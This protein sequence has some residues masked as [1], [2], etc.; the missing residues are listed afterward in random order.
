MLSSH[1][2]ITTQTIDNNL[3]QQKKI[4]LQVLRLDKVHPIISGNKIFKLH[5][6][7]EGLDKKAGKT[8]ITF[9]GAYSNHLVATAYTCK[10]NGITCVGIVRG[11]APKQLSHTLQHCTE[12]GMQLQFISREAYHQK[13]NNDFTGQ[14]QQQYENAIIIPEGGYAIAGAK[15]AALIM[16]HVADEITHICCAAG[17]STTAA[18][19]LS[20]IKP[21]QQLIVF[22]VLKGLN[23]I[24]Q[25]F[26]F[27]TGKNFNKE[28]LHIRD[29]YH[30]GGYAKKTVELIQFM[31]TLYNEH[32]LPT[33]FVYTGKMMYGVMNLLQ[34]NF[35]LPGSKVL[36]IHTGGL[37][38]NLSL[39][40]GTLTF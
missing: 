8:I 7:I 2:N 28:Q 26:D 13:E 27:L 32:W 40:A 20:N 6:Y 12:Y 29:G 15:G 23:D 16:N 30:F 18:G 35:F 11:E 3:L 38:G 25:R 33:D 24:D 37:Q 17:T 21:H 1:P 39:P 5:Y 4:Q 36:C 19:L 34:N 31:N 10:L 14:L 22:P 9:G